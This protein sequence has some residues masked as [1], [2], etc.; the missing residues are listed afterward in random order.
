MLQCL[1]LTLTEYV[2]SKA[3]TSSP[4]LIHAQ[5]PGLSNEMGLGQHRMLGNVTDQRWHRH[6][7]A[8]LVCTAE[9]AN[10]GFEV[11]DDVHSSTQQT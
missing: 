11:T 4:H 8:F 2:V 3:A 1:S 5:V 9:Q 7:V 6:W 10:H